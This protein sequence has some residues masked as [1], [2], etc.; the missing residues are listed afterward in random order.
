MNPAFRQYSFMGGKMAKW[1][2][3]DI[4]IGEG[5]IIIRILTRVRA[6]YLSLC[7]IFFAYPLARGEESP[8]PLSVSLSFL[9]VLQI[10]SVFF[11]LAH[12]GKAK[13]SFWQASIADSARP[14]YVSRLVQS[15]HR[16]THAYAYQRQAPLSVQISYSLSKSLFSYTART[17]EGKHIA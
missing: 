7:L 1:R 5:L 13:E 17:D 6:S 14:D 8:L 3:S 15:L 4:I 9:A 2:E 12:Q 11:A 16:H 10:Q